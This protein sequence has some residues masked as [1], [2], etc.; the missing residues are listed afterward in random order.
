MTAMSHSPRLVLFMGCAGSGK[1]TLARQVL[2]RRPM[3][4]LNKDTVWRALV[5]LVPS[6]E[7]Y[8]EH[9]EDW[10]TMLYAVVEENLIVGASVLLDAPHVR[11]AQDP[12]WSA[13][14]N[15]LVDRAGADLCAVYCHCPETLLQQ[16]LRERGVERDQRKLDNWEEFRRAEPIVV[17]VPFPHIMIDTAR[18]IDECVERVVGYLSG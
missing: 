5:P 1:T 15:Q 10:Y 7:E 17:P 4:Y 9:R 8:L 3:A 14:M 6:R 16:R 18:P 2:K 12:V 13:E 11:Q